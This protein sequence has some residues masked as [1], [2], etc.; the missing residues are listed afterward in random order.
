VAGL[1]SLRFRYSFRKYQRM[2]LA[3]V[4]SGRGGNK[5][6]IVAPPGSGKTIVG[7]ELIRRFGERAVVFTPTT[8]I[9]QQW[10]E[11]V[12]MFTQA[13][14]G[15]L[16]SQDPNALADIN[17]FTYQLISTPSGSRSFLREAAVK[18]WIEELLLG[19]RASDEDTARE[20]LESLRKN[21]PRAFALELSRRRPRAKREL[22]RRKDADVARFLHPNA[23]GLISDLI[24][25]GVKTVVLDECHHLL[26]YWAVVLRHLVSR[27]EEPRVV[28]LTATLP[29]P[30]D[31]REYEN[32]TALLGEIDFEVPTPAVVK[33]GDLAPYRDLAYITEPTGRELEYLDNVQR[34]FEE[35]I[36]VLT[37]SEDFREWV[38]ERMLLGEPLENLLREEPAFSLATLRFL[39]RIGR[40]IPAD[41][42]TIPLEAN[43]PLTLEDWAELL[44]HYGLDHLRPSSRAEDHRKLAELRRILLPFG[45]T[46]TEGGLRASRSPGDLVLA[47]SES[48]D[49]AV[50][51]ILTA[52]SETLGEMLRA[53]VVTDFERMS[54]G[55]RPEEALDHEAGSAQRVFERLVYHRETGRLNPVLITGRAVL[56]D[57]D[58]GL[59]LI[60]RF[61]EHL[62][63]KDLRA[64]CRYERTKIPGIL[65]VAGEG[66]DWSSRA[67]VAMV[68]AAFEEG[69]TR[70]LVGTRG[71]LGE[72]WD[73]LTLNTLVDL[74]SV[75]TSTS[76]QQLRGRSL[77][78]NPLWPR[79][80]AHNWDVICVANGFE[81][82]DSD[83]KRLVRRH[84]RYWGLE[85]PPRV[86][87]VLAGGRARIVKGISH[88]SPAL[89]FELAIRSFK[90][91]SFDRH[92]RAALAQV[93]RREESYELWGV[94]EEYSN[95]ALSSARLETKALKIRTAYT[96]QNS[97]KSML[98]EFRLSIVLIL[99]GSLFLGV[100]YALGA[101][102]GGILILGASLG[103]SI[104]FLFNL[105]S[106]YR[107]GRALLVEQRPDA[108]LLDVGRA[109]LEALK[110]AGLVGRNLAPDDVRVIEQG[111]GIHEI[112]LDHA[113]PVHA[114]TFVLSYRQIFAPVRD[115]RYLILR[116]EDRL[117]N[118]ALRPLWFSLRLFLRRR[119]HFPSSYHPVPDLLATRKERAE[120][121]ARY[122]ERY[123]GG[124]E[125]VYTRTDKGRRALLK[126]RAEH[127]PEP[128]SLAFEVWR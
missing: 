105:R 73:S 86:E 113:S 58:L 109:L 82:G 45:L 107:L 10:I 114:A 3:H 94:G 48:K 85:P 79:K 55:A 50:C 106:A 65:E 76:V 39:R 54:S 104:A 12:G 19:G 40:S 44:E 71:I 24:D 90:Q 112:S 124:G 87:R 37:D 74:T 98:R 28:G 41:P 69:V 95:L 14:A 8:T 42:L 70:C 59:G 52:E 63:G 110:D 61:N 100:L 115:Q 21:N 84:N 119:S 38:A 122:W 30:E 67:Y 1:G 33:E 47:F 57:A 126:A 35:E 64:T 18:M 29:S 96:L 7:L 99:L 116:D 123:V 66:R 89:A 125:L 16:V 128:G 2:I 11:E 25:H 13:P 51:R 46:L 53:V 97:L 92:T 72:G 111:D 118:V 101:P 9:Q 103:A 75:T 83:L 56:A 20:R 34:A 5:H 36:S 80:V 6:H 32:Y 68:T 49:E 60:D 62:R 120:A 91:I 22:L 15:E 78:R 88:V 108:I 127:R 27:V 93:G 4:E 81:R 31:D 26:D 102:P 77:R 43:E 121:L 17:V 23:R 117:S